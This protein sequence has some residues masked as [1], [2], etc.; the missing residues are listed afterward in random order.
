M[1][2]LELS[3]WAGSKQDPL[4]PTVGFVPWLTAGPPRAEW[5]LHLF[6]NPFFHVSL[7]LLNPGGWGVSVGGKDTVGWEQPLRTSQQGREGGGLEP[8]RRGPAEQ[9]CCAPPA[10][11]WEHNIS[12][13]VQFSSV[14]SLSRVQLFVTPWITAR[15]ASPSITNSWNFR[16]L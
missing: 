9:T 14:Q 11:S 12:H 8:S 1:F 16:C 7:T 13:S 3:W 2:T 15:Q 6:P 10:G 5:S 4:H